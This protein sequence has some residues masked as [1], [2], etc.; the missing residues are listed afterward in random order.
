MIEIF[1]KKK[2][3]K[4]LICLKNTQK[5]WTLRLLCEESK[6]TYVYLMRILPKI[7]QYG[8]ISEER[9]GKRKVLK[10]TEKGTKLATLF[11]EMERIENDT[12]S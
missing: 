7:K 9:K 11:E 10:L 3:S 2:P 4:I 1:I 8:L 12:T 6:M 5:E